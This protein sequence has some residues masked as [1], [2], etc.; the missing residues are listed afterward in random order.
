MRCL[1]TLWKSWE[2]MPD[3]A[4]PD[5]RF[6]CIIGAQ[7]SGSTWLHQMLDAHPA[8]QM[9]KPVAPEPKYFL[10]GA[11]STSTCSREEYLLRYFPDA[12]SGQVLGEKS[13]SYIEHPEVAARILSLFPQAKAIAILR[14]PVARALSNHRFSVQRGLEGRSFRQ[15]FH[16]ELPAPPIPPGTSVDPFDYLGR[17]H[18][19]PQLQPWLDVLGDALRIEIME[20]LQASPEQLQELYAWLGVER[21]YVP[22]DFRSTPNATAE[23]D[24]IAAD[25]DVI[26]KLSAHFAPEISTLEIHLGRSIPRWH[27]PI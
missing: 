2:T 25:P 19:L 24:R 21:E 16:D 4:G 12:R 20:E 5:T 17:S 15:V 6:V 7:R 9:A 11:G 23:A 27:D 10:H 14:H 3:H 13:T 26:R 22:P 18:Y 1:G 8:I